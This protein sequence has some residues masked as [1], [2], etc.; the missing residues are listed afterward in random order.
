MPLFNHYGAGGW[1]GGIWSGEVEAASPYPMWKQFLWP[2]GGQMRHLKTFIL[3]EGRRYQDLIP[4]PNQLSPNQAGKPKSLQGWAYCA[5]TA[6]R[7]LFLAYFEQDCPQAALSGARVGGRYQAAWF[8]PREGIWGE[9]AVP[10]VADTA[11]IITL[12]PFPG[13]KNKSED[14]WAL[15]LKLITK[16]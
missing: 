12:P 15:K 14:D 16:P 11:G 5:H 4:A 7:D 1:G 13:G 6:E 10:L 8:N 2:S 3:S 9:E